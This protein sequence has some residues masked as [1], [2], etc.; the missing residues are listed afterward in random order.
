MTDEKMRQF[1]KRMTD[2]P[3]WLE[4]CV[5]MQE[6]INAVLDDRERAE[7]E[8]QPAGDVP[9]WFCDVVRAIHDDGFKCARIECGCDNEAAIGKVNMIPQ[10]WRK[11]EAEIA[12]RVAAATKERD[13]EI[14]R[15]KAELAAATTP[16]EDYGF[17]E[18]RGPGG[19]VFLAVHRGDFQRERAAR[20]A[21]EERER[22]LR[23]LIQTRYLATRT[24]TGVFEPRAHGPAT[25]KQFE[26]ALVA[27]RVQQV[28][29]AK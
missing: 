18:A 10:A 1:A 3:T 21:A 2:A 11:V 16:V 8:P 25:D 29:G 13:A 5:V 4:G 15:L 9:A 28:G 20:L 17:I 7:P 22:E 23:E 24:G 6:F 19:K 12:R 27:Y 14:E 26:E